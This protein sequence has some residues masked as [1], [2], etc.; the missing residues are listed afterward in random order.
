MLEIIRKFVLFTAISLLISGCAASQAVDDRDRAISNV[1]KDAARN[2]QASFDYHSATSYFT[3]LYELEPD[4]INALIGLAQNLRYSG[5]SRQSIKI[6]RNGIKKHGNN[7]KLIIELAK[8]QLSSS[9]IVDA[10]ETL[11]QARELAPDNWEVHSVSGILFDRQGKYQMAQNSYQR[12][13]QLNPN[14]SS[15]MNNLGLSLAQSGKLDD[16]IKVLE[17][18]VNSENSNIQ[19]RQNLALLYGLKGNFNDAE[20]LIREDLPPEAVAENMAT[21]R[22]YYSRTS[23]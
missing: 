9:M 6:L 3:K 2:A 18:L 10:D 23:K 13:L 8:S 11:V 5:S 4:N 17:R 16:G 21:L 19:G 1:L 12:A 22:R 14:N 20:R 15:V 7:P